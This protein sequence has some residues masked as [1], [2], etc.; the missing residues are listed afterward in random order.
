[1]DNGAFGKTDA[2]APVIASM[3]FDVMS[4]NHNGAL[5]LSSDR[6][7]DHD[8]LASAARTVQEAFNKKQTK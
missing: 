3:L 1:V 7:E 4:S 2:M 8:A 6:P 5:L